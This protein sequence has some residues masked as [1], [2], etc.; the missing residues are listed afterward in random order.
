MRKKIKNLLVVMDG[1]G[2][3]PIKALDGKTPLEAA[4]T[5]ALNTLANGAATGLIDIAEGNAPE[6]DTGVLTLLGLNP[7][8]F[9]IGRGAIEALGAG[10]KFKNNWLALRAN[11]ATCH[12]NKIIDRRVGRSLTREE[13]RILEK[14]LNKKIRLKNAT[15]KF[16]ATISHRGVLI[17]KAKSLSKKISNTDPAY[18]TK[19]GKITVALK[20]FSPKIKKC[21]PL[22]STTTAKK[23]ARIV[24]EFTTAAKKVLEESVVN[25]KRAARGLPQANCLLLRDAETRIPKPP[26]NALAYLRNW[27]LLADM[28]VEIGIGRLLG[29]H[30]KKISVETPGEKLAEQALKLLKKNAGVYVHLKGP[31]LYAH[32]GNVT[33]KIESIKKLDADFFSTLLKKIDLR[34]TRIT[35]TADHA[36][37]CE[38][39]AHSGD[40][41][42]FLIAG[43]NVSGNG[44][45]FTE[46]AC[47]QTKTKIPGFKL[48]SILNKKY[49]TKNTLNSTK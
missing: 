31:D 39:K 7:K 1:V 14:E 36:T 11:F 48:V 13:T 3:R 5:P 25:K 24:N 43:A 37:P 40:P 35:V 27:A 28:P 42:P 22:N 6:S 10:L 32:D 44:T 49:I 9:R 30:V 2:D 18:A 47:A 34:S 8:K 20:K 45:K 41:V 17:I 19:T 33:G 46:R 12:D 29:L 38:L 26:R 21:K 4:E 23:T 16:K 15:F